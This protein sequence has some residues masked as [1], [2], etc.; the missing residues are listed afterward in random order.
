MKLYDDGDILGVAFK[1]VDG[2]IFT[3]INP[4]KHDTLKREVGF[5]LGYLPD[6]E[7]GFYTKNI[8]FMNRF[9]SRKYAKRYLGLK[10]DDLELTSDHLW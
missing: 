4:N 6:G 3:M 5:E 10:T 1:S 8:E 9:V 7:W 2:Q